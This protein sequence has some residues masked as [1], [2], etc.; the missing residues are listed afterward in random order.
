MD[1]EDPALETSIDASEVGLPLFVPDPTPT[2][3]PYL[4]PFDIPE[5]SPRS[6]SPT[7]PSMHTVP[8]DAPLDMP[9]L[10]TAEMR[11]W[12]DRIRA[13]PDIPLLRRWLRERGAGATMHLA[14]TTSFI[15]VEVEFQGR[16]VPLVA[17]TFM[18]HIRYLLMRADGVDADS[19]SLPDGM[20]V[21]RL[22][23]LKLL[24]RSTTLRKY[25][26][27]VGPPL[28]DLFCRLI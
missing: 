21:A 5:L 12:P 27:L 3:S 17:E 2:P 25:K 24:L 16:N 7:L 20:Q 18:A 9:A 23:S 6:P 14:P 4:Q 13:Q 22:Y 10:L 19:P 28:I 26:M 8:N 15:P 1:E 11:R